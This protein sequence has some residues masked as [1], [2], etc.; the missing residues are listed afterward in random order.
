MSERRPGV[1]LVTTFLQGGAGRAI[2]DLATGLRVSGRRVAVVTSRTPVG[3]NCNYAEYLATLG[4]SGVETVAIDSTFSRERDHNRTAAA[5]IAEA[6]DLNEF[7]VVHA[8]AATPSRIALLLASRT[9]RPLAVVQT[10]HGWGVNKTKEHEAQDIATMNLVARVVTTSRTSAEDMIGRGVSELR[11][12]TIPCGI[13]EGV[14]PDPLPADV[15]AI[16]GAK[17]RGMAL[18]ACIGSINRQKNQPLLVE[19]LARLDRSLN[20]GV[21]FVGEGTGIGMLQSLAHERGVADRVWCLGYRPS[22]SSLLAHVDLLAQTSIE[23]GQGVA[24]LEAMRARVP[25]VSSDIPVLRELVVDGR[26]GF[27]FRSNDP[28][29]LAATLTQALHRPQPERDAICDRAHALFEQRYTLSA[30]RRSHDAL[31]DLVS[32]A[33]APQFT[34]HT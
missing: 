17:A 8:H 13:A 9:E 2:V 1:L 24:I 30:M 3:D 18:V 32:K 31:Y 10:M 27:L 4:K 20:V 5:V 6:V 28:D 26:T 22:A 23:E 11:V 34:I 16:A 19:A 33:E 25:V 15:N 7:G 29:S 21:L 14:R 12:V